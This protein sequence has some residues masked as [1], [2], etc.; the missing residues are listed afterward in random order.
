MTSPQPACLTRTND[1]YQQIGRRSEKRPPRNGIWLASL[2]PVQE[3]VTDGYKLTPRVF[4][5]SSGSITFRVGSVD[6]AGILLGILRAA[7]PRHGVRG[8]ERKNAFLP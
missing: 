1:R 6:A 4:R 7:L 3:F 8:D 2:D 5:H